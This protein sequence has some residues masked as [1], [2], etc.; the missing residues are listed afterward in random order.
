MFVYLWLICLVM[1]F[2][3]IFFYRYLHEIISKVQS[4]G[5]GFQ[6]WI[7]TLYN[8]LLNSKQFKDR[9]TGQWTSHYSICKILNNMSP[10]MKSTS[11]VYLQIT[12][13]NLEKKLQ[14]ISILQIYIQYICN[15][16]I[17]STWIPIFI[18]RPK[19]A[20]LFFNIRFLWLLVNIRF[21]WS[22]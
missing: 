1:I 19:L 15:Y 4:I 3:L 18:Y 9:W 7:K 10:T 14:K 5:W 22:L 21:L 16:S 13:Y 12:L 2:F 17:S 20:R 11:S 8:F 6:I